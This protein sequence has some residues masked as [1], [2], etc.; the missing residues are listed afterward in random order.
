MSL[1]LAEN[2]VVVGADNRPPMLDKT[3]YSSWASRMLLYIKGKEH[4]KLLVD[5][6]LNGPFQY[7]TMAEPGN[8]T[9]PATIRART[10]TNLTDEENI[11]ESV[12][13]KAI[14]I[15]LQGLSHD[16]YNLVNHNEDA[17]QIWDRPHI[18]PSPTVHQQQYQTPVLQQSF[19]APA[20][21]QSSSTE[22]D[23]G[24]TSSNPRNQATIQDRRVTVQTVQGRQTHGYANNGERNTATNQ[25]VNRQGAASQARVVK[26][27]NCQ[28]EGHFAR[29][30][31]KPKRPKNS[32]WFKEKLSSA[33]QDALLMSFIEEMSSQVAK[34]NKV[35]QENIVVNETLTAKLER[36][37]EQVKLFEQRQKFDLNDRE[38]YINGQLRQTHVALS[39]TDSEETLELAEESRLKMQAKQNDPSLK[40]KKVNIGPVDYVALNKPSE[41]FVKHFV[42]Q[43]QLSA[44]QAFWLPISQPVSIKLPVPSE[45]ILKKEIPRELPSISMHIIGQDVM[46]T[47]M[48]VNDHYDNVLLANN[49][50]LDHDNSTLDLLKHENDRLMELLISHD[51]VHNAVNSLVVINDYKSMQQSFMDEYN[52]TLLQAQL[53]AKN[54]SIKKL[55]EHIANIKGKNVVESVQNLQ[56]SNVVT[57]KVYKLDVQ[58]LSPLVKHNRDAHVNYLKHTQENADTLR[59]IIE[60][61]RELRPLNSN[62]DSACKFVTRIQ[63]LLVYVNQTCPSTKPVSN[64][65]VVVTP[66]NRTR[67]VRFAE[68]GD[69]SKDKTQKQ[70]QPQDKPTTNNYVSPSTRVS[71]FTEASGSKPRSNTK[72]DRISQTSRSNKKTNKVEAQ[73]RIAKSSLNN[74][75]SVLK[76]VC[77]QNVKHSMLNANSELVC[78]TC[79]ECMFDAI[80]DLCVSNYLNDVNARVKSKSVKSRSAKSK[81]KKMWKPTGKVYTNVGYSWKPTGRTFT[82]NGNTCPLT[83]IIYTNVVP[84][85]KSISTTPVKKTQP[86]SNKSGKL[87]DIT[88]VVQIILWYLDSGCSKYMTGQL[89]QIINFV[90]KFLGTI[91]FG[92]DQIAKIMGYSDYRLG[93]VT[94][95]RVYYVEGLGHNLFSVGQFCNSDLEFF[96]PPPSVV[97][98][99]PVAAAPRP[100]DPTGSPVSNLIDHDAPSASNPSTQEQEQSPIIF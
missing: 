74:T 19:Q 64:K 86:S 14:N 26:C 3:N 79:H 67:K 29:Q 46:N 42:P 12:D 28:E 69:T 9:T 24:L 40:E 99:V 43:K 41:H 17:K 90:S 91:R 2:V 100:V 71:S 21:Q 13:I 83:R 16:I 53:K 34:C 63:E 95:S 77:N 76:T 1:S 96:N 98:P 51:L 62:L 87:K 44:E 10:Y 61:A 52:E 85:R 56:N 38:K 22:L 49:N 72:K 68:S 5:S 75:N 60:H 31:T 18:T 8:E 59:E 58:P 36:Y 66:I 20:I 93:N 97:S 6:V 94:I 15:V 7:G 47:V 88:N 25:G 78:T 23:S 57:S 45:P 81:K 32:A 50:S 4:G 11:C 80:H 37:K 73:R 84:P 35:Q 30:C 65:L 92:N 70:V 27:Y 54:V 39:I 55:K 48:H 33:Q 82:I 89:S